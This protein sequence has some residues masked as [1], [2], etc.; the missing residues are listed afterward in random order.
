MKAVGFHD[1]IRV[2]DVP[3]PHLQAPTDSIVGI[4]SKVLTQ[5][6]PLR[7]AMDAYRALDSR[8]QGW[9]KGELKP[10]FA[11][12]TAASEKVYRPFGPSCG[13]SFHP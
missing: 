2:D 3:E 5:M 7:A 9:I 11:M 13:W 10:A 1:D 4:T 6:E 12:A 8:Q